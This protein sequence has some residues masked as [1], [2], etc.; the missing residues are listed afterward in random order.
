[1]IKIK[2]HEAPTLADYTAAIDARVESAARSRRY[3]SA[4]HMASY[5]SST[6]PEW[7]AEAE[8]FVS[9]RDAVWTYALAQF[10]AVESGSPAPTIPEIIA[11]LPSPAWP[12]A[13]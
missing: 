4:A 6:V 1:M 3:N 5:V 9:W 10:A 13:S 11:S 2:P 8:A 7:A 12:S